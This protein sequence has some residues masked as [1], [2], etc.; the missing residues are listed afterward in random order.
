MTSRL[1][2]DTP[3]LGMT[4]CFVSGLGGDEST[5]TSSEWLMVAE[6][7]LSVKGDLGCKRDYAR[8]LQK[9]MLLFLI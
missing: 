6:E 8:K 9:I 3:P 5:G 2:D 7:S 4:F 1:L